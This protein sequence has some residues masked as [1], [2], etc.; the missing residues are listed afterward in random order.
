MNINSIIKNHIQTIETQL[1]VDFKE[2][3]LRPLMFINNINFNENDDIYAITHLE[4]F[5]SKEVVSLK[6]RQ[7]RDNMFSTVNLIGDDAIYIT[8]GCENLEELK[9]ALTK[10]DY[11]I[12]SETKFM[13]LK[14]EASEFLNIE[15]NDFN[16]IKSYISFADSN[17]DTIFANKE[18]IMYSLFVELINRGY[19]NTLIETTLEENIKS[20]K[21]SYIDNSYKGLEFRKLKSS[22]S[23]EMK[24]ELEHL[25]NFSIAMSTYND[26]V[27]KYIDNALKTRN[28][29]DVQSGLLNDRLIMHRYKKDCYKYILSLVD[30]YINE[31]DLS[32][33]IFNIKSTELYCIMEDA[34]I[35]RNSIEE[36]TEFTNFLSIL[37]EYFQNSLSS[38]A[39]SF[40]LKQNIISKISNK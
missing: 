40:I 15:I 2:K 5:D 9:N 34:F 8:W 24:E 13:D 14:A 27:G 31:E 39:N 30:I 35:L 17:I 28:L 19:K 4:L 12:S 20:Y 33:Y 11:P 16:D 6:S 7:D 38:V 25:K 29:N 10:W 26:N 21:L 37:G 23:L 3:S 36:E 32:N 18:T 22:L 1:T